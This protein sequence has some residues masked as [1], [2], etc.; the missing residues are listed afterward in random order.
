MFKKLLITLVVVAMVVGVAYARDV[1]V[2]NVSISNVNPTAGTCT[3]NYTLTRTQPAIDANQPIWV[4]VKYRLS[5]DTDFTGWQD[6][7]DHDA[8]NDDS[9]G[10]FTGN[11]GS[12]NA[13]SNTVNKYLNGDVGIVTSGGSKQI[14]WMWGSGGTNLNSTDQVRVR[15]YAVEM[16][17]VPDGGAMTFGTDTDAV[18]EITSGTY[19]PAS[20][21]YLMKYPCTAEMYAAFLNCCVN[22]HDNDAD[23]HLYFYTSQMT[24]G[25][26]DDRLDMTSGSIGTTDAVFTANSGQKD[27]A[28]TYVGWWNAYDWCKWAGLRMPTE[29]EFEYEASYVGNRDFPW[30]DTPVPDSGSNIYCNMNGVSPSNASDVKTYD[31]G[32]SGNQGLSANKAAEMSGNVCEWQFTGW[33]TGSYDSNYGTEGQAGYDSG[34]C[35][36]VRGGVWGLDASW[37]RAGSRDISSPSHHGNDYGFRAARTQ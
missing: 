20:A 1:T 15:V 35:R 6:T 24:D 36:V 11:N 17:L 37:M 25:D 9:D 23:N 33:Y 27:Y 29:E 30:G 22:R 19:N 2:S 13:V 18:N 3:I 16:V 34:S 28:M 21:Y 8:T 4:F 12:Q 10:R 14:M 7:D 32:G 31:E 5:T 26:S